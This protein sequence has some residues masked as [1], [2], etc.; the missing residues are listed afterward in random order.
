ME[1]LETQKKIYLKI[2]LDREHNC[3]IITYAN[4]GDW[5]HSKIIAERPHEIKTIKVDFLKNLRM[6][7]LLNIAVDLGIEN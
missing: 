4:L 5:K 6:D 2:N 3:P 1:K 7:E